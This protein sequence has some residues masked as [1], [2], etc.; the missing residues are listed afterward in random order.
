MQIR[1]LILFIIII[2]KKAQ[3]LLKF[4][5][6]IRN[7]TITPIIKSITNE[8]EFCKP[9]FMITNHYPGGE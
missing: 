7:T 6:P 1:V 4:V 9:K 2:T 5:S 8:F 3:I